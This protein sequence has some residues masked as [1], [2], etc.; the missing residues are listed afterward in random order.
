VKRFL[1][2]LSLVALATTS[3]TASTAPAPAKK[4][5]T[6]PPYRLAAHR[7]VPAPADEYFGK[8]KMSIL[9]IRN[10]I[11]DV[12]ANIDIDASRAPGLM[13]KC[14]FAEDAIHDWERHYPTDTWLPKTIFS[15]ERMYA[16]IDS[17]DGRRRSMA[18]MTWLVHD[19]PQTWYGRTGRKEI[20]EHRVGHPAAPIATAAGDS[21]P[22]GNQSTFSGVV[23]PST[24]VTA[25]TA[26]SPAPAQ[27][28]NPH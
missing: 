12:G 6:H 23:I 5:A 18:A 8:L 11:K 1:A 7:P 25:G 28:A 2:C 27:V 26:S 16:K 10:T 17:D 19:Y 4:P 3:A 22:S 24:K 9:G 15:L 21:A 13:G 20:A 14:D